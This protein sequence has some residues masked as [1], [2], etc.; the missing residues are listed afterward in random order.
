M[1]LLHAL[2]SLRL[3]T[4]PQS[5]R[6]GDAG[7]AARARYRPSLEAVEGRVLLAGVSWISQFSG[8][9]EDPSNWST[10]RVPTADDDV[11]IDKPG[12]T[13]TQGLV[14]GFRVHSLTSTDAIVI[15]AGLLAFT[16]DS[17]IANTLTIAPN[18]GLDVN[19]HRLVVGGLFT[20][21]GGWM[22][23]GTLVA[24][25]GMALGG[26]G[27]T[28]DLR[29]D[30]TLDNFGAA[31]W[32]GPGNTINMG[33]GT[34]KNEAGATFTA[35]GGPGLS[36]VGGLL[37]A[38]END[39]TFVNDTA[40]GTTSLLVPFTSTGAVTVSRGNLA[41]DFGGTASGSFHAAG[42]ALDF[43]RS[44]ALAAGST[45]DGGTVSFSSGTDTV[46]AALTH[47]A[48]LDVLFGGI[49]NFGSDAFDAGTLSVAGTMNSS[50]TIG[51]GTLDVL[52]AGGILH[53]SGSVSVG[54]RFHWYGGRVDG[55]GRLTVR[56]GATMDLGGGATR[57]DFYYG[58]LD[59]FG[60]ATW[61]GAG[62]TFYVLYGAVFNN[63][64]GASFTAQTDGEITGSGGVLP[65]FNNAGTFAKDTTTGITRVT[66]P[67]N[68]TGGTIAAR[69]GTIRLDGGGADT[70]G[71]YQAAAGA[72]VNL[73]G[74]RAVTGT[75]GG[76]GTG[77]VTFGGSLNIGAGGATFN[78]PGTLFQLGSGRINVGANTLTI[79]SQGTV[80]IVASRGGSFA[81]SSTGSLVNRG[82][83]DET[84]GTFNLPLLLDNTG[85][86][87]IHDGGINVSRVAQLSNG[88][89]TAGAW[90][91]L[92]TNVE[93]PLTIASAN[94]T[95]ATL[96]PRATVVLS[97]PNARFTN[98]GGLATNQGRFSVLGGQIF[99]T[100]GN[101][102]DSGE[103]TLGPGSTLAVRG[104]FTETSTG[105]VTIQLGG[106]A[107]TPK[108]GRLTTGV[109]GGVRLAGALVVT[110]TVVPDVGTGFTILDNQ[111]SSAVSGTFAGLGQGATFTVTVKG[112]VMTFRISY[113]GGTGNDVTL[114]RI[115]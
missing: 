32:S 15:K 39:G 102:S 45:V 66:L 21:S 56:P 92:S 38:F 18:A 10:H 42:A 20:C 59:N 11:T 63:R 34:I 58:T 112:A 90:Q 108:I 98:L 13:V 31:T 40:A 35:R 48:E 72:T 64:P 51:V 44:Y 96:G 2:H 4:H 111:S 93:S 53:S 12:V 29:N 71:T 61:G 33:H 89:L 49:V 69:T 91:V 55:T 36:S 46:A 28:E 84:G 76:S 104:S 41:L 47:V 52:S 110:S 78:F 79:G 23:G 8:N 1:A 105:T 6:R 65:A 17:S 87:T 7:R 100:A 60:T 67:F 62:N 70:G 22:S 5:P 27:L 16:T 109:S 83:I 19:G 88:T 14:S 68:N 81:A 115:S 54:S 94:S 95:I 77:V 3:G 86:V 85:T 43:G 97:G 37:G 106:S 73:G 57:E 113:V 24:N 101:L 99:T 9:W 50:G 74:T 103:L 75:Y 107:T 25:G 82:T 30:F 80:T 26:N 114:K